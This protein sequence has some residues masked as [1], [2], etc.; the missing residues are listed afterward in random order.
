MDES[1]SIQNSL[2]STS[3][4]LGQA[5]EVKNSLLRQPRRDGGASSIAAAAAAAASAA[6]PL[7]TPS[8]TAAFSQLLELRPQ[9]L[10]E[11]VVGI[12]L[13]EQHL[14]LLLLTLGVALKVLDARRH[15]LESLAILRE[16]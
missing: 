7:G 16:L 11:L 13:I 9:R 14:E 3:G 8:A 15:R 5:A 1:K 2:T 12:G 4:V 10:D 6:G